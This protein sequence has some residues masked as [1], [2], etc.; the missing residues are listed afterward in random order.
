MCQ[1]RLELSQF[2][3]LL[4]GRFVLS[5]VGR[6]ADEPLQISGVGKDRMANSADPLHLS[7][8]KKNAELMIVT[9]FFRDY[10]FDLALPLEAILRVDAFGIFFPSRRSLDWV[11]AVNPVELTRKVH[12]P[13][14]RH[15]PGPT[16]RVSHLL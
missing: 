5:N 8:R 13:P 16:R 4:L 10:P 12:C 11:E 2:F 9:G 6:T 3:A 7:V 1:V 14:I 15:A